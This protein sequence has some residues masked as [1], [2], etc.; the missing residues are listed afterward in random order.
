MGR[1]LDLERVRTSFGAAA[2][3]GFETRG[4]FM[5]GY[6][7]E[8]RE[9][10]DQ[11]VDLALSLP[12]DWASF[13]RTIGLPRTELYSEMQRRGLVVGDFWRDYTVLRFGGRMP[14]IKDE[15]FLRSAQRRAYR[16]FFGRRRVLAGKLRDI[17]SAHRLREYVEGAKLF[18]AIQTE[19]NRNA[20]ATMWRRTT[21]QD[22]I[23]LREIADRPTEPSTGGYEAF[24]G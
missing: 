21:S 14:Y 18:L 7:D 13:S 22:D 6:L 17:T 9:E 12:L 8:T 3:L 15:D 11:T 2:D 1:N 23:E 24:M 16:R 10:T 20:P 19:A 4:Y 5:L